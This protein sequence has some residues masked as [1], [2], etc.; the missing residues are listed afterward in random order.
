MNE[1]SWSEVILIHAQTQVDR[2]ERNAIQYMSERTGQKGRGQIGEIL[3]GHSSS[4]EIS[5][6]YRFSNNEVFR[7]KILFQ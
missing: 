3:C 7:W 2:Q 4:P 5:F 1:I 6:F